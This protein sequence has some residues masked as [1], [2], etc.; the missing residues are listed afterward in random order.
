MY[1]NAGNAPG[2]TSSDSGQGGAL[3]RFT[4]R[5][6]Q[7]L[8]T[9]QGFREQRQ[10]GGQTVLSPTTSISDPSGYNSTGP[11]YAAQGEQQPQL[12]QQAQPH[13]SQQPAYHSARTGQ[14]S[15]VN[16]GLAS[17]SQPVSSSSRSPYQH[18]DSPQT[19]APHPQQ[20][21]SP[22]DAPSIL[23]IVTADAR[24][25]YP[26]RSYSNQQQQ[27]QQPQQQQS[28][29]PPSSEDSSMSASNNGSLPAPKA[30]RAGS[31]NRQSMHNGLNSREASALSA[32]QNGGQQGG[33]VPAF[34]ASVVPP[35]GQ[36]QAYPGAPQQQQK[37]ADIGRVTPQP[38][39]TSEDMTE[40]DI[41]QLIKDHKE[42]RMQPTR[43]P[44][45][46]IES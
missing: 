38:V 26:S 22:P 44:I 43:I 9:E 21:Y 30:V 36:A 35:A 34:S 27:Q 25:Q 31:T 20:Q 37:S 13:P 1:Q 5:R 15:H 41:N 17:Q 39:Q 46:R 29:Q 40:E 42:L 18:Q 4:Q 16:A 23:H 6:L 32:G 2:K 3:D 10:G 8:N 12:H 14:A 19:H 45:E 11:S 28:S 33:G 7:R 24:T